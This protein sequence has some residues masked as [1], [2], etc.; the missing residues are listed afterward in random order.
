MSAP[1]VLC[2]TPMQDL[3]RLG[4]ESRMNTPGSAQ[5]NWQWRCT[6]GQINEGTGEWLLRTTRLY[7]R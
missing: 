2:I 3:I 4:T 5:G 6:D 7:A 1:A